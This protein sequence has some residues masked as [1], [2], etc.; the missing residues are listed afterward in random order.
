M[1][2]HFYSL[3]WIYWILKN[4]FLLPFYLLFCLILISFQIYTFYTFCY[5]IESS[6][7]CTSTNY[8]F[9]K[10][11]LQIYHDLHIYIYIYIYIYILYLSPFGAVCAVCTFLNSYIL[12][13]ILS[14]NQICF[15]YH[16]Y[17]LFTIYVCMYNIYIYIY[18][19]YIYI[20]IIYIY[21]YK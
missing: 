2:D 18:I 11:V 6:K 14:K 12:I 19:V 9:F 21:I 20:Y 7:V 5:F 3:Y 16:I 4:Y 13:F 15:A 1:W 17:K 10:F 8:L